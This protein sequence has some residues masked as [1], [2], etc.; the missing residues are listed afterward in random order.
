[1]QQH[2]WSSPWLGNVGTDFWFLF[3]R[4][5]DVG[6]NMYPSVYYLNSIS[7]CVAKQ[8]KPQ[9]NSRRGKQKNLTWLWYFRKQ[10]N[11]L[12]CVCV[13]KYLQFLLLFL[14]LHLTL[15]QGLACLILD[16]L[17]ALSFEG[18][19]LGLVGQFCYPA[20]STQLELTKPREQIDGH[21]DNILDIKIFCLLTLAEDR[22]PGGGVLSSVQGWCF[23][24]QSEWRSHSAHSFSWCWLIVCDG[25]TPLPQTLSVS[26]ETM[27]YPPVGLPLGLSDD[28]AQVGPNCPHHHCTWNEERLVNVPRAL[29]YS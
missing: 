26:A 28:L 4:I 2:E 21:K 3:L 22:L 9:I 27:G 13:C 11:A 18:V 5:D 19:Q 23:V 1:M 12:L 7:R 25:L 17:S 14:T 16:Q 6:W 20:V 24:P 15:S 29:I 10:V 8:P